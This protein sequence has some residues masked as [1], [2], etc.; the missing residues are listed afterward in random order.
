MSEQPVSHIDLVPTL[1]DALG[2]SVPAHLQG[3]SLLPFLRGEVDALETPYIVVEQN[4]PD[5][6][7][8][9]RR[10]SEWPAQGSRPHPDKQLAERAADFATEAQIR[11][12]Y[13]EPVRTVISPELMKLN[14]HRDGERELYDLKADPDETEN[15]AGRAENA[16]TAEEL[17]GR[18]FDWQV[19]TRDPV[20][21]P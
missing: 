15:I 16:D 5:A 20:Y 6:P 17:T 18:I 14:Y 1:L 3:D 4:G 2:Q 12:A 9:D 7:G 8:I 10:K 11:R 21:L 13:L 19:R